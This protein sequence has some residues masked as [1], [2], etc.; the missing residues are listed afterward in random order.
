MDTILA[1]QPAQGDSLTD[2]LETQT[3]QANA[4]ILELQQTRG[5][6][7]KSTVAA[8]VINGTDAA[9]ANVGDSRVYYLHNRAIAKI[10]ED[11]SVAYKNTNQERLPE[12]RLAPMRIS[13]ACCGHSGIPRGTS[14]TAALRS[15]PLNR[16][17]VSSSAT[18][19]CGSISWMK[20]Y[21]SIF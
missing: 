15:I 4:N 3:R 12:R 9:W 19:E 11:H 2:W 17:M 10:T 14:P 21:W 7:M 13:P 1:R 18:T 8:L 20:R 5:G 16:E 6:N